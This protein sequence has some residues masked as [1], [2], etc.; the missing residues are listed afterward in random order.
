MPFCGSIASISSVG[1]GCAVLASLLFAGDSRPAAAPLRLAVYYGYPSLV[2][3]AA[4]DLSRASSEF[5]RY[6]VLILGD[7]LQLDP[8]DGATDADNERARARRVIGLLRAAP[9]GPEIFGYVDLGDTQRL[10]DDEVVRRIEAW[11]AIGAHGVFLDEAGYDFGVT[12][13]RQNLAV[14]AA[15]ARGMSVCLNAFRPGDVFGTEA[16]PL[17]ARGGGNPRGVAPLLTARDGFLL[18]SFAVVD[19]R[20]EAT[21]A[22]LARSRIALAGRETY[23]TRV[24]AVATAGSDPGWPLAEYGWWMAA[25]LGI[26]A[27]GWGMPAYSA[28]TSALPWV[29]RPGP[30]AVLRKAEYRAAVD[31][32]DGLCVRSTSAGRIVVDTRMRTGALERP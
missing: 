11:A 32:G 31:V 8:R 30:E 18:E 13:E 12:R 29:P 7:G 3:G 2:N 16:V 26:D 6:D 5:L 24:F 14:R 9:R 28:V 19:G 15:H 21:D 17:N 1:S 23:G 10:S 27:Y 4:G 25:A 22:L 20:P